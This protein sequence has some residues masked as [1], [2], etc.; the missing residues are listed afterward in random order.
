MK[1]SRRKSTKASQKLPDDYVEQCARSALRKAKNIKEFDIPSSLWVNSDR[2]QVIY[3]P[4]DKMTWAETGAKQ[5][6][7][8]GVEEKRV[9]TLMVSIASDGQVLPFQAIYEG[10]TEKSVPSKDARNRRECDDIGC[11]FHFSGMKTYW[12]NQETMRS[13]VEEILVPYFDRQR[14]RLGLPAN[15]KAM[16]TIDVYS[17]HRSEEFRAYM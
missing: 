15:Q 1:W 17:V 7:S 2:T 9:F 5:V 8:V 4:G 3:A 11:C 10:K 12:S 13:F 6:G 16:W 14:K